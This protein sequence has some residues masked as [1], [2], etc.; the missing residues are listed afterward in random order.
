MHGRAIGITLATAWIAVL[1]SDCL[2]EN[3]QEDF[4]RG[5]DM[6]YSNRY[7]EAED[8]FLALARRL[9]R[10]KLADADLWRARALFQA[11]RISHLYLNQPQRAIQRMREA[12]KLQ[13]EA[14][15]SFEARLEIAGIYQDRIHDLRAAATEFERLVHDYPKQ[16][17]IDA[18][19]YRVAQCY[20]MLRDYEQSRTEARLLL[21]RWP[22]GKFAG[23]ARLLIAN[24]FYLEGK[25]TEAIEAHQ[26]LLDSHPIAAIRSRAYFELGLCY[27]DQ[28][29]NI[30][31]EQAFLAALKEHPRPDL[32]QIQL[33]AIRERVRQED[34]KAKP[35]SYATDGRTYD[36]RAN[37][38]QKSVQTESSKAQEEPSAEKKAP[39][40]PEP[41]KDKAP[42]PE[43]PE[44][45]S[46][47]KE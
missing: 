31:A 38:A 9:D 47:E 24:A 30:K 5:V 26:R 14:D 10:S 33:S 19:Q 46:G 32:V 37:N 36:G 6:L 25:R 45:E 40:S 39:A 27:A 35:L 21:E 17:G 8:H 41:A 34:E 23:E 12:I 42:E 20:L 16:E 43:P 11:G 2:S 1:C 7:T 18:Y 22:D 29:E 44:Q 4:D 15:F 13:P 28:A 3:V